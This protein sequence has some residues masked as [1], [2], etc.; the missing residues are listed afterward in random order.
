M[1]EFIETINHQLGQKFNTQICNVL[2][3]GAGGAGL[4]AAIEAHGQGLDVIVCGKRHRDDA[5]TV[6]A[7]GGINAAFGNVDK[8]DSWQQHFADTYIEGY[9]IGEPE[10]IEIMAKESPECVSEIDNWGA[11]FA[12]TE[13][14]EIDQRFF[15]AHTYRRT[16]YSGDYTGQSILKTLVNRAE[17]LQIPIHDS[18]Y[19]TGLLV[20]QNIC[21]GAISFN[22]KTGS[23]T[24]FLADAIVLATGGH[25]RIWRRSSSRKHENHGDGLYLG[26]QAGCQ[27]IDMEMVQFHP[28]GMLAP[29]EY[30]GTLVTEAVR[31]EGGKLFN[32]KGERFMQKYDSERM[33]LSTRDRIALANYTEI[34]EGRGTPNGGIYLDI[35]HKE[36]SFII[37]KIPS[38]YRQFIDL[39]MLDI[40]KKPMEV[41]P[42]AHYSMGGLHVSPNEH[43]TAVE[44]LYAAGEVAGG[45]HG[46]NRLG[47]NSLAEILVFG[48]RAGRAAA[49]KSLSTETL[50]RS[51]SVINAELQK[52]DDMVRDG[53]EI[54]KQIEY[55]LNELMWN[56]CGVVRNEDLLKKGL[57]KLEKLKSR[58]ENLDIR[59]DTYSADELVMGFNLKAS[60]CAAE[61]TLLSAIERRESRG[62]HQR[63]DY[64]DISSEQSVNY[65]ISMDSKNQIAITKKE[66]S[67]L[68]PTLK[69]VLAKTNK[70]NDFSGKLLE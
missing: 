69:E 68:Q 60:I 3:I 5:H 15:G 4:S 24:V 41:A 28:T 7:A 47:G 37:E 8:E 66:L 46:A 17:A 50:I 44:G 45:L 36:K 67:K 18:E 59:V 42:T 38:I 54:P 56:H 10:I 57:E 25:T 21:F 34:S 43:A 11:N 51:R 40:S 58:A 55:D 23:R 52:I 22:K 6:L 48:K 30:A 20:E 2:V 33:E 31:G 14:G 63:S 16:C 70:I 65:F 61:A 9:G 12:K 13:T 39:Q 64:P 62:S 53:E 27:L 35:S 29:D 32:A 26:L 1:L 19:I 49:Q